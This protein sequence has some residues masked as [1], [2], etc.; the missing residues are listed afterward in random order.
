MTSAGTR[1]GSCS[2][3]AEPPSENAARG[4]PP[5][6]H[7]EGV[8][9]EARRGSSKQSRGRRRLRDEQ[10]RA[11]PPHTVSVPEALVRAADALPSP[12]GGR[13]YSSSCSSRSAAWRRRRSFASTR[14]A[15]SWAPGAA[16]SSTA[17]RSC[18]RSWADTAGLRRGEE[19]QWR[20]ILSQTTWVRAGGGCQ[21]RPGGLLEGSLLDP[22]PPSGEKATP[23]AVE[24]PRGKLRVTLRKN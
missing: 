17:A 16:H 2:S 5:S 20:R 19:N 22:N 8:T 21:L 7:F 4:I 3:T 10:R 13:G 12:R 18:R 6:C 24:M 11:A 23:G 9:G 1:Q 14:G 15:A